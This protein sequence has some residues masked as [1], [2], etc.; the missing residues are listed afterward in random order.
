MFN[1]MVGNFQA[2]LEDLTEDV[3]SCNANR[4]EASTQCSNDANN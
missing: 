1:V 3:I 4:D 2:Q